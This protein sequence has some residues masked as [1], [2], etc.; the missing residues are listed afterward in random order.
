MYFGNSFLGALG[1]LDRILF[2][3]ETQRSQRS[4]QVD[5]FD[6]Q[7][8]FSAYSAPPRGNLGSASV[9]RQRLL[10][11]IVDQSLDT[12]SKYGHV[13]IDQESDRPTT[14]PEVCQ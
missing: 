1:G 10:F 4:E 14:D 8:C 12:F 3:A 5:P 2:T 13:E 7:F 9:S 6:T 11:K